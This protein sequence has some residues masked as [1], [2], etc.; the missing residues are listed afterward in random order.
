MFAA[1]EE[2]LA[3]VRAGISGAA[4]RAG[5]SEDEV[6][7]IA[8]T[9]TLRIEAVEAAAALGVEDFG[10][11]YIQ[12]LRGKASERPDL[13]WHYI[14]ALQS[15]T[16]HHVAD[17]ADYVHGLEPGGAVTRL[18]ERAASRGKNLPV[19][20]QV[21]FEGGR[22]GVAPE[23]LDVFVQEVASLDGLVLSGLMTLPPMPESPEDCR[24][25]FRRLR[26]MRDRLRK[27][28]PV[29]VELSM[30]MSLD[31]EVAVEEGATMVR[32]GTALFGERTK[33]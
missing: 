22:N 21:D 24:P 16:A 10:E 27:T 3:R 29:L 15:G 8:V 26:E 1:L 6:R 31:Y 13:H 32:V 30:G 23:Q 4:T 9:K 14:G 25:Y 5:R 20:V 18:S 7:L 33:R 19:L 28:H 12:E 11:N 2:N 17:V